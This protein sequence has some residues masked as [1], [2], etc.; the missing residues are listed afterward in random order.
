MSDDPILY[1]TKTG[2]DNVESM[3]THVTWALNLHCGG[4]MNS[5]IVKTL[6][7]SVFCLSFL[8][9]NPPTFLS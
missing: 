6:N 1:K 3:C 2:R 9:E 8:V 5:L 7:I 4:D